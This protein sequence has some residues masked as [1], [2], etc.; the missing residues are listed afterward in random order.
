MEQTE[1]RPPEQVSVC[2]Q[3][4][5]VSCQLSAGRSGCIQCPILR[6][7]RGLRARL[8]TVTQG[9]PCPTP[10]TNLAWLIRQ[11]GLCYLDF[12]R[13]FLWFNAGAIGVR[14]YLGELC[15]KEKDLGG[16]V[17]PQEESDQRAG[18]TIR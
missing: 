8:S 13:M 5:V 18:C 15:A 14:V 1:L 16:I 4:S 6:D 9:G 10:Q 17:N 2:C 12:Y 3:L 7:L 11:H